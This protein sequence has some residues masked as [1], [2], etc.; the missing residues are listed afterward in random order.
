[1]RTLS[2][3]LLVALCA[4]LLV[5][6]GAAENAESGMTVMETITSFKNSIPD[7]SALDNLAI[8]AKKELGMPIRAL[9]FSWNAGK[10]TCGADYGSTLT[11]KG[12]V[13]DNGNRLQVI[14]D[15]A[16]FDY[17]LYLPDGYDPAKKYPMILF[18]HGIGE[19]GDDPSVIAEYG[20]FQ[21]I[22]KGHS[23]GMIVIAPQLEKENHWVDN[24][25]GAEYDGQIDRLKIFLSQ[26]REAWPVDDRRIYL[27]G[28][29][30]GGRG[31]WKLACAMPDTFAALAVVCGR[32]SVWD[33]PENYVYD[34]TR[35]KGMPVWIFHGLGDTT[36]APDH[37][38]A[39]AR[40]LRAE[41][42]EGE[43]NLTLY[44]VVGH[45]SYDFAYTDSRL[46]AWLEEHILAD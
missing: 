32:A 15:Q 37:G 2:R 25:K 28:L 40:K 46:Y 21:Y 39:A 27:T 9:D 26:M 36:V 12:Y 5:S 41:D 45:N 6:G 44:P 17:L 14:R 3:I 13:K 30:M 29:S 24:A 34:L 11:N 33:Q 10:F 42:P 18:L 16:E 20:P 38:L 8:R 4:A 35:L 22:L 43:L 19:R 7:A 31:S 1:M 23:L